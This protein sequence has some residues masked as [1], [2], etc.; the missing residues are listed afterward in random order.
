M[1]DDAQTR[2]R[3]TTRLRVHV[4]KT[5]RRR[6]EQ[7][8]RAAVTHSQERPPSVAVFPISRNGPELDAFGPELDFI[9]G[10]T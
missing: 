2:R 1:Q 7:A 5:S 9:V 8:Q 3:R 10:Y 4:G 6:P